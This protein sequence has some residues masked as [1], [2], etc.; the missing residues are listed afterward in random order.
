MLPLY[1]GEYVPKQNSI[2]FQS[3]EEI[4][5]TVENPMIENRRFEKKNNMIACTSYIR[6]YDVPENKEIFIY[7]FKHVKTDKI[8]NYILI[9]CQSDEF[10]QNIKLFDF[11]SNKFINE[12]IQKRDFK[13][14]EWSLMIL[15]KRKNFF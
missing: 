2:D 10:Y 7:G 4:L 12:E 13:T 15:V 8:D 9:R 6:N 11:W 1:E 3:A 5:M 14:P